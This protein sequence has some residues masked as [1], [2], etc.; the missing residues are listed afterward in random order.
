MLLETPLCDFGWQAPTFKLKDF[1]GKDY[2]FENLMGPKGLLVMFICNHCP[3]VKAIVQQL[4]EDAK[5]IQTKGVG[6]V[7][8]MANDYKH[9]PDDSPA[10]MKAFATENDFSFPYL[11]DETQDVGKA[12][13]AICT[14][15]FFGFNNQGQLQ[16]RGRLDDK[17]MEEQPDGRVKEL[18]NAMERIA[19][20]GEGP[21]EQYPSMGCS[22]KWR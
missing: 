4:V 15:D 11:I 2:N 7:A 21:K 22:I 17:R 18:V 13:Q 14:P 3:Y 10:K 19:Q 20:T 16:Y 9:Y 5:T 8:I 6:V 1:D 12:Y